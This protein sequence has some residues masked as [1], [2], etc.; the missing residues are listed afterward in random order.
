MTGTRRSASAA[1]IKVGARRA[2]WPIA[3][4]TLPRQ[5]LTSSTIAIW[6]TSMTMTIAS[7]TSIQSP[8]GGCSP[9]GTCGSTIETM[10]AG[11]RIRPSATGTISLRLRLERGL[12]F[13]PRLA[14]R[15]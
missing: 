7:A 11:N 12:G 8:A 4:P 14:D 9:A 10:T 1:R 2:A 15:Q 6:P 5:P 13:V 3:S